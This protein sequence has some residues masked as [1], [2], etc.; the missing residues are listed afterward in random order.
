M[1]HCN[2]CD[3]NL[4]NSEFGIRAASKDGLASKCKLCQKIYDK[5]RANDDHRKMAR[6]IYAQT[7]E[8][9]I[10]GNKAKAAYRKRNPIKQRAHEVVSYAIR[11]GHLFKKPCEVCG[12]E[13]SIH[14]HHDDYL[15]P[16]NVRWLCC[17]HHKQWHRDN[18]EGLNR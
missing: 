7:E 9:K 14:A 8:G 15:E 5:H 17:A 1:K 6:E 10:A 13:E 11:K 18:G 16:L 3:R 12:T 4:F 2:S